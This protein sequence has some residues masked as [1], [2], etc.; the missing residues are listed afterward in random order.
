MKVSVDIEIAV[1]KEVLWSA[2]TDIENC[3]KMISSIID[4]QILRQPEDG[5]VG[6]KWKETALAC[7]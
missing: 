3:S 7:Y 2:I 1:P 4:L 5:L 6:L